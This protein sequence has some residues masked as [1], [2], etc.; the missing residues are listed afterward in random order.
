MSNQF[1]R[2]AAAAAVLCM[3]AAVTIG[4]GP[5]SAAPHTVDGIS[6]ELPMPPGFCELTREHPY[7]R[8]LHEQQDRM[9]SAHNQVIA[10]FA[11]CGEIE[12]MRQGMPA[13]RHGMWLLSAPNGQVVR[14]PANQ[15]R[16]AFLD[17]VAAALPKVESGKLAAEMGQRA[18]REQL[19]LSLQKIGVIDRNDDAVYLGILASVAVAGADPRHSAGVVAITTIRQRGLTFNL[20]GEYGGQGTYDELLAQTKQVMVALVAANATPVARDGD[21]PAG[22]RALET[23]AAASDDL[24]DWQRLL[25]KGAIG[26]AIA[27]A[28]AGGVAL[29][30]M[31]RRPA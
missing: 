27:G 8:A 13:S 15:R 14:V 22:M 18:R 23:G 10:I 29:W 25:I 19:D 26:A 9:Q 6:M 3:A 2:A 1:N 21:L 24:I 20:Y 7:D 30:R 5:A 28:L 11:P 16:S 4:A 17:E 31:L 12:T